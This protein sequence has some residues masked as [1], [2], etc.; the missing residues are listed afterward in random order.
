MTVTELTSTLFVWCTPSKYGGAA[1]LK[2]S[3]IMKRTYANAK[4]LK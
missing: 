4:R 2:L 1:P 3:L